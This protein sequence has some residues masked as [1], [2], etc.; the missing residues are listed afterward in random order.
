MLPHR[1]Q[2][3]PDWMKQLRDAPWVDDAAWGS[4]YLDDP[5]RDLDPD[6]G[7]MMLSLHM[8]RV[9]EQHPGRH[10]SLSFRTLWSRSLI[11]VEAHPFNLF[12]FD[13]RF[14]P[15]SDRRALE[16]LGGAEPGS[17]LPPD[18]PVDVAAS[19]L[20]GNSTTRESLTIS[21]KSALELFDLAALCAMDPGEATT[22]A[23][24]RERL[25]DW[26]D[27][28]RLRGLADVLNAYEYS[29]LLYEAAATAKDPELSAGFSR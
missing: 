29:A 27:D 25:R 14:R 10:P 17:R 28:E 20:R 13:V 7:M 1:M 4:A 6:A 15:S 2:S 22:I 16:L 5:W 26:T 19:L 12:V 8:K 21:E 23:R 3:P 11:T 9:M 18:L 24:L